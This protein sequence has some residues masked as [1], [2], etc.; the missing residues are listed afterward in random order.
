MS[1]VTVNGLM[2]QRRKQ[3]RAAIER[4]HHLSNEMQTISFI[5]EDKAGRCYTYRGV[6]YCYG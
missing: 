5:R 3:A 4:E 2:R 1:N 6:E